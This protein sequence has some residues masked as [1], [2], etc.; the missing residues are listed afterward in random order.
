[1]LQDDARFR[2][3]DAGVTASLPADPHAGRDQLV[4]ASVDGTSL[5][6]LYAKLERPAAA[7]RR[8]TAGA[9][10]TNEIFVERL[11]LANRGAGWTTVTSRKVPPPAGAGCRTSIVV[12]SGMTNDHALAVIEQCASVDVGDSVSTSDCALAAERYASGAWQH[13]ALSTKLQSFNE[14]IAARDSDRVAVPADNSARTFR[15]Y[16]LTGPTAALEGDF[17]GFPIALEGNELARGDSSGKP[18][19]SGVGYRIFVDELRSGT[20][21]AAA[22][23]VETT[24]RDWGIELGAA[25]SLVVLDEDASSARLYTRA[26][27]KW[28]LVAPLPLD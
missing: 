9:V 19:P 1:M 13:Y 2:A 11:D 27:G 7:C 5:F 16:R 20:W 12:S 24:G 8:L 10:V 6:A 15:V 21:V 17:A 18:G 26:L 23:A 25:P 22:D 14:P 3:C 28:T 4:D